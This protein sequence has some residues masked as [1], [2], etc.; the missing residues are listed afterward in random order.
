M[1]SDKEKKIIRE[2]AKKWIDA[3]NL[4]VM[5]ERKRQWKAMNDL[6]AERPMILIETWYIQDY[7]NHDE[8]ICSDPFLH[9]IEK[10]LRWVIRHVQ[11][12]GDDIV[13]E[14]YFRLPWEVGQTDYGMPV[15]LISGHL[16]NVETTGFTYNFPV[17]TPDDIKKIQ[18]IP[19]KIDRAK[20]KSEESMLMD[21]M[22]DILPV[23]AGGN[24]PF[25]F[26]SGF[27]PWVGNNFFGLTWDV[28]KLLGNNKLLLWVYDKPDAIHDLM[29]HLED[30]KI[31]QFNWMIE[32][33]LLEL[34]TDNQFAGAG[35]YGY[36]SDL[37]RPDYN[38]TVRTQD[39]WGWAESQETG[40]PII[41]PEMFCEFF[42][43]HISVLS[44]MFGLIY[45]GC[46]E[47]LH[48][49]WE[50]II[51]EI[52]NIRAVSISGWSDF[53]KM[54]DFLGKGFVYSRKP[55][56]AYISG[57]SPN[58]DLLKK[59]LYS[60]IK[61][62]SDINLEFIFRDIYTIEGDRPRL[63]KWVEMAKSALNI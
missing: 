28:I 47:G 49:R 8:I 35:R 13:V 53:Q 37:P 4:P 41:S 31:K 17:Q 42:L 19:R 29:S 16:D 23:K 59:D 56:P 11:E 51:K 21:I 63:K 12:I 9:N 45:Y 44:K 36:V 57:K 3:A 34:N 40:P 39:L 2:L 6:K 1:I 50:Y 60:T 32:E 46:C 10:S 27:R 24:D 20:T 54:A 18:Y 25:H 15:E 52:P 33:K 14:P 43:P 58:W 38:G 55:I 30:I 62:A 26:D 7:I 22:G 48:D 61:A 5:N